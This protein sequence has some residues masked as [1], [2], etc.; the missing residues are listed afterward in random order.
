MEAKGCNCVIDEPLGGGDSTARKQEPID[1]PKDA[2][3][4]DSG[5]PQPGRRHHLHVASQSQHPTK[6]S[7]ARR[8]SAQENERS[9]CT[10]GVTV[11]TL[12]SASYHNSLPIWSPMLGS[13][14]IVDQFSL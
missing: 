8:C 4:Q 11:A 5:R 13:R 12:G 9:I 10:A 6:T 3:D 1:R 14:L 7:G 2:W